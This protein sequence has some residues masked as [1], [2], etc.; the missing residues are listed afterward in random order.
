MKVTKLCENKKH[1][2]MSR[3]LIHIIYQEFKINLSRFLLIFFNFQ[4]NLIQKYKHEF[5]SVIDVN[6]YYFLL[7]INSWLSICLSSFTAI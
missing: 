2:E 6:F 7:H 3:N 5:W 1:D 4:D